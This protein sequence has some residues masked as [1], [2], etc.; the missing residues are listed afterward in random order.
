MLW[1]NRKGKEEG[2]VDGEKD[3]DG[4]GEDKPGKG[5]KGG[6]GKG[7]KGKGGKEDEG[8]VEGDKDQDVDTDSKGGKGG[9]RG[10]RGRKLQTEDAPC[11][12]VFIEVESEVYDVKGD[13]TQSW[14]E[15]VMAQV[16]VVYAN[17]GQN[18]Q[19]SEF[20]IWNVEDPFV[21]T[22][23]EKLDGFMDKW[24]ANIEDG[25]DFNGDIAHLVGFTGGGGVAYVD[26]L[27]NDWY[28]YGMSAVDST[29][30]EVPLFSWTVMV[31][32][33]EIGHQYG[34][35]HTHDCE[36]SSTG[37]GTEAIDCC[38]PNAGYAGIGCP[39][40][41]CSLDVEPDFGT[42]MSYCHI[43]NTGIDLGEGFHPWVAI[44]FEDRV[45]AASCLGTCSVCPTF[46][47]DADE[48]G[49]GDANTSETTCDGVP[50][51]YVD[52]S[53]DCDDTNADVTTGDQ[54]YQDADADGY[55]NADVSTT[56]CTQPTGYVSDNTD[57]ND[58]SAD[59]NPGATEVCDLIDNDCNDLVD[60]DDDNVDASTFTVYYGDVDG[61]GFGSSSDQ[62][63]SCQPAEG[64]VANTEDCND[65]DPLQYNGAACDW[66]DPNNADLTC[67][68]TYAT[69]GDAC[70][71]QAADDDADGVCN[72]ADQCP[73]EDDN[74]DANEDGIPDCQ[75]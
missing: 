50:D 60:D 37:Y 15:E 25:I 1:E 6:K 71:C 53:D 73:G 26:V 47:A 43:T 41:T 34:A 59:A 5:G 66:T 12:K 52:N 40:S 28:G 63:S 7:G 42:V 23:G 2:D 13:E 74:L 48:D 36:W 22:T 72:D 27:C 31:I 51:G 20:Y 35:G 70:A 9:K 11:V 8:E 46:Y 3:F 24:T 61:D 39:S 68:S 32:S 55:G 16:A 4:E 57:C 49:L 17:A 58:D 18:L 62:S 44:R 30:S 10:G 14:M 29:Y 38:G 54:F 69:E 75:E 21:G 67:T 65:A 45:A 33:H 64:Y 56:A 19:V